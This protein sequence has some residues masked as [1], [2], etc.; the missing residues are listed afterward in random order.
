MFIFSYLLLDSNLSL[1][2]D[3]ISIFLAANSGTQFLHEFIE[4]GG[5][6]TVLEIVDMNV[7]RDVILK[8]YHS[9]E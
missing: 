9:N 6:I 8:C 4:I 5:I 2:L 3:A 1:Q 7:I